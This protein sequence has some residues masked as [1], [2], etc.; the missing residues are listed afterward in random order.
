MNNN[1]IGVILLL[2]ALAGTV[3]VK[4]SDS[5][6]LQYLKMKGI[7]DAKK[8]TTNFFL[9][10]LQKNKNISLDDAILKFENSENNSLEEFSRSKNR[11]AESYREAYNEM[12][13]KAK[14]KLK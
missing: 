8:L 12:F 9:D 4:C 2:G 14:R 6:K 3:Y 10:L 1:T 11:T 13:E 5:I 7:H